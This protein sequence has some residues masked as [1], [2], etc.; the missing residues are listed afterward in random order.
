M[1]SFD[2]AFRRMQAADSAAVAA[3]E[4]EQVRRA[5]WADAAAPL[6]TRM[7]QDFAR[8]LY[9]R[10]RPARVPA[11]NYWKKGMFSGKNVDILSPDGIRFIAA[12]IVALNTA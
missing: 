6:V 2:E 10:V 12:A 5:Q 7:V 1:S 3:R 8:S 9:G 11:G 4:V